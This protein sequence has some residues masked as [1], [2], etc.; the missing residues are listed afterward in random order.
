[1]SQTTDLRDDALRITE[2]GEGSG[3]YASRDE[4]VAAIE[5]GQKG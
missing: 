4:A 3:D 5:D 2:T 1:M